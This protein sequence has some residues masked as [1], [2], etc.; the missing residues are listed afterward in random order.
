MMARMSSTS[1]RSETQGQRARPPKLPSSS[2]STHKPKEV[3]G[4]GKRP[5]AAEELARSVVPPVSAAAADAAAATFFENFKIAQ[6]VACSSPTVATHTVIPLMDPSKRL[7]P[8]MF[9]LSFIL[10]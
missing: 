9:T 10:T 2:S 3:A 4:P 5:S 7:K 8:G 1:Q 6:A